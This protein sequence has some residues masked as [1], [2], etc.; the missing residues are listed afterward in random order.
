[1]DDMYDDDEFTDISEDDI[2]SPVKKPTPA[3]GGADNVDDMLSDFD[4]MLAKVKRDQQ[5]RELTREQEREE[6][7]APSPP[8]PPPSPPPQESS[9]SFLD[10]EPAA[11]AAQPARAGRRGPKPAVSSESDPLDP[12]A[13]PRERAS[14]PFDNK[15]TAP[16]SIRIDSSH[17]IGCKLTES[18]TLWESLF[19]WAGAARKTRGLAQK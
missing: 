11:P 4:A 15:I 9:F 2:D 16:A 1:M 7:K 18:F 17:E 3:K 6:F 12:F 5:K 10:S 8:K 14:D 19:G 13:R